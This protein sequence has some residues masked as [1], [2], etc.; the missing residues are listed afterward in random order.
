[1]SISDTNDSE[2]NIDKR[3]N[4]FCILRTFDETWEKTIVV[5]VFIIIILVAVAGC[6]F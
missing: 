3:T 1:M 6:C 2:Q 4:A 5:V